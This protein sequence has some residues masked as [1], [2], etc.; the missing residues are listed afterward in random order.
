MNAPAVIGHNLPPDIIDETLAPFGDVISEAESWLDGQKV[1]TEGQMKAADALLKGIKAARKA[2]D[3]ARDLS[4][5]PLHDAWKGEVARWKPTQDDLDRLAKGLIA[6][7]DDF[8][9]KLAAEKEAARKEAERLAWEETRKA[10]EAARLA[11]ASNI[12]ATRAAAAQ[13]EA[14]E[15]AQRRAAEAAKDTVKGLRTVTRYEIT[16]HKALLNWIAKNDRDAIT[17]FIEDY[18]RKEHKVIANADGIRV[19]TEKQAF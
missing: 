18:A 15:D 16:D 7:L 12:E 3:E 10:Q 19:W 8:K 13:M 14:A 9:R 6:L 5:K 2:V 11:D 17:A 1:E 4:T